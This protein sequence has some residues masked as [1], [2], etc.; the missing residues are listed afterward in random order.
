MVMKEV[1]ERKDERERGTTGKRVDKGNGTTDGSL[2][3]L[4][5]LLRYGREREDEGTSHTWVTIS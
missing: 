1:R 2:K 5:V 4:T 3:F